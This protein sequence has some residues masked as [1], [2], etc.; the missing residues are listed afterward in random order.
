M[1]MAYGS[2]TVA[3]IA[4][5]SGWQPDRLR[6]GVVLTGYV[7]G[8]AGLVVWHPEP[9]ARELYREHDGKA[10]RS[11]WPGWRQAVAPWESR[12]SSRSSS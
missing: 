2:F 5:G 8:L 6:A 12:R 3:F 4:H 10:E 9:T 7:V 1:I 11:T